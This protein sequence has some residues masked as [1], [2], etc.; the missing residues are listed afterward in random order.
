MQRH[1]ALLILIVLMACAPADREQR[2]AAGVDQPTADAVPA[3]DTG[4]PA[5][6]A[7]APPQRG[8]MVSLRGTAGETQGYL[9]LPQETGAQIRRPAVIVIHEWWGLN[10]WIR[11]T[12]DRFA[13]QGYVAL[14]V[15]LY[16]GAQASDDKEAHEL[17]RG[18]PED[19]A[20]ADLKAG[21]EYLASNPSVDP[22]RI[23]SIGW[24]MGGGYSL[25]LAAAEPRLRACVINYGRLITDP[26]AISRIRSPILG[27]FAG[28]DRGIAVADVK[29][30]QQA[31][32]AA[33]IQNDIKVYPGRAHAFMNP[34]NAEGYDPEATK[35]AWQR[36]DRFFLLELKGQ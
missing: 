29:R 10:D 32:Q 28:A 3:A 14:A 15:D 16:R 13:D 35:D 21:F 4:S 7:T 36:I 11:Q 34:N 23:G 31:L 22:K 30:F 6:S 1:C 27:N 25:A 19:R 26:A 5:G 9:S 24:C 2:R 18:M 33:G 17:M 20:L 12:T 8:S